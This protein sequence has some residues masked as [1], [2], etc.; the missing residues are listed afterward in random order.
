MEREIRHFSDSAAKT[1]SMQRG[2][3]RSALHVIEPRQGRLHAVRLGEDGVRCSAGRDPPSRRFA[4]S[5]GAEPDGPPRGSAGPA[6]P[7]RGSR[8]QNPARA[9]QGERGRRRA[10]AVAA[11]PPKEPMAGYDR[12]A[13][14][15]LVSVSLGR[16][17]FRRGQTRA[18]RPAE[19]A[20]RPQ[21]LWLDFC[22]RPDSF[23]AQRYC[24]KRGIR[25]VSQVSLRYSP[26]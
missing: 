12:L 26:R 20:G 23:D 15:P 13:Q 11:F 17:N 21:R 19:S 14:A 18:R 1:S 10:G 2:R 8:A 4:P 25:D 9:T 3:G 16:R 24:S 22:H 6:A 7:P 5:G